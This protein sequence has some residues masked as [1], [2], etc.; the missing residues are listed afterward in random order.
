[1][2]RTINLAEHDL[3]WYRNRGVDAL[4][5]VD[6][7]FQ[8]FLDDPTEDPEMTANYRELLDE[9]CV[10]FEAEGGAFETQDSDHRIVVLRLPP[11]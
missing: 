1:V 9:G 6:V 11:C 8:P 5:A 7:T 2:V 10:T 3:A 4:V